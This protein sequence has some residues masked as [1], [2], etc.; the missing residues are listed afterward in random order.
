MLGRQV[1]RTP[2]GTVSEEIAVTDHRSRAERLLL[3]AA[4]AALWLAVFAAPAHAAFPGQNG[5]IVFGMGDGSLYSMNP[6]GLG[7]LS[8]PVGH[9]ITVPRCHRTDKGLPS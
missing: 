5:K 3:L 4:C 8:S 2:R 9:R 7:K 6:D 1:S